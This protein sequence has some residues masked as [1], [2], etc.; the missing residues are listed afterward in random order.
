MSAP[1]ETESLTD[2]QP[3]QSAQQS[4]ALVV[5]QDRVDNPPYAIGLGEAESSAVGAAA[6]E[7]VTVFV[8]VETPAL[9]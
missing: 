2:T 8:P 3:D 9:L 1:V 4:E 6:T 7:T 5:D